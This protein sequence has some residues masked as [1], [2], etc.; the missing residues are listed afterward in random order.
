[1]SPEQQDQQPVEEP[2]PHRRRRRWWLLAVP[3]VVVVAGVAWLVVALLTPS[4]FTVNGEV[5]IYPTCG[6]DVAVGGQVVILDKASEPL[7]VGSLAQAP[8]SAC[9]RTFSVPGV[10]AGEETYGVR[11]G[12]EQRGVVWHSEAELR[13]GVHLKIG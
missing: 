1:M 12:D 6:G 9:K 5:S 11:V 2:R 3:A 10:P 13:G 7:A 8:G 4:T